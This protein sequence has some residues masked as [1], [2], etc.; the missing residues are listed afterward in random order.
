QPGI[1]IGLPNWMGISLVDAKGK[2]FQLTSIGQR[3]ANQ[4]KAQTLIFKPAQGQGEPAKLIFTG[5]RTVTVDIPFKFKDVKLPGSA[6]LFSR[7][8]IGERGR[9]APLSGRG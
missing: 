4:G 2:P 1:A 6:L 3:G 9:R 7:D 8:P 5:Q